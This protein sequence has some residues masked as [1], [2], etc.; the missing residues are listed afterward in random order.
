MRRLPILVA[1]CGLGVVACTPPPPPP[2]PP[3]PGYSVTLT[4][5][6]GALG[7]T[8]V[9]G[10][11][12]DTGPVAGNFVIALQ[13]S[14]GAVSNGFSFNVLPGETAV[15]FSILSGTVT[16]QIS[17]VQAVAASPPAVAAQAAVTS[18]EVA[19]GFT[20]VKG[21]VTNSGAAPSSFTIELLASS[22]SV[23]TARASNVGPGQSAPWQ[24]MFQGDVTASIVR[25]TS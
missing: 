11:I 22:G 15:W 25:V 9:S 16:A 24:A 7:L 23:G 18:R 3:V 19:F 14:S 21:M 1:A 12:T 10:T 5:T 20:T 17:G 4:R 13:A 6:F 2:P 8:T